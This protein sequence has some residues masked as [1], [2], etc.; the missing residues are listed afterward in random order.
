MASTNKKTVVLTGAGGF[1]GLNLSR[2]FAEQGYKVIGLEIN[3]ECLDEI[4]ACG[5]EAVEC[6][7]LKDDLVPIFK[8]ADYLIHIAGLFRFDAPTRVMLTVNRDLV[9]VVLEAASKV[10]FKHIVHFST[11]AIYGSPLTFPIT[12]KYP[13][14]PNDNYGKTKLMG[15]KIA[16]EYFKEKN[17]PISIIRPTLIYG[18]GNP[19]GIGQFI[20]FGSLLMDGLRLKRMINLKG[21]THMHLVNVK[22]IARICHFLMEREETIGEV[23]NAA[24][25]TP[26]PVGKFIETIMSVYKDTKVMSILPH[27]KLLIKKLNSILIKKT[28]PLDPVNKLLGKIWNHFARRTNILP[29]KFHLNI[30]PD[31]VGYFIEDL[32]YSNKKLHELGFEFEYPHP[33]KGVLENIIWYKKNKWIP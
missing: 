24:D 31:W 5:A 8:D 32:A 20:A 13:Q 6:D 12:E 17:L 21:G 15:E 7:L 1:V 10:N 11:T 16:W 9:D 3:K 27:P 29:D 28:I 33:K 23:Y 30:S 2:Y 14:K 18:P 19:Y 26:M 25:D 4:S 22:D